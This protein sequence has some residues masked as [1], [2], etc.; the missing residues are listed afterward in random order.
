[1]SCGWP[2]ALRARP[3]WQDEG[4]CERLELKLWLFPTSAVD[5][6]AGLRLTE[7]NSCSQ[8]VPHLQDVSHLQLGHLPSRLKDPRVVTAQEAQ[9][10]DMAMKAR[11]RERRGAF[12]RWASQETEEGMTGASKE[13]V[14]ERFAAQAAAPKEP[15]RLRGELAVGSPVAIVYVVGSE[16]STDS[17]VQP[18][19]KEGRAELARQIGRFIWRSLAEEYTESS[20]RDRL[21]LRN[22]VYAIFAD[23]YGA[24]LSQPRVTR[25]YQ[26]VASSCKRGP[27][28]GQSV[29]IGFATEW[30]AQLAFE[31]AGVAWPGL[32]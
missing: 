7:K 12:A 21:Q 23:Y 19:D 8:G 28:C 4:I 29:F 2:G 22:R 14:S 25:E 26:V 24:R 5:D 6:E 1:M 11:V 9:P 16:V 20:G 32:S 13:I 31:E 30:E 18:S 10:E 3:E 27:S 17:V 15:Y